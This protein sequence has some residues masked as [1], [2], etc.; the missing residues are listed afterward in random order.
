M[1]RMNYDEQGFMCDVWCTVLLKRH[2]RC[3]VM[4]SRYR[5]SQILEDPVTKTEERRG[6]VCSEVEIIILPKE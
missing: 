6:E 5:R 3:Q 4:A 2:L 1:K